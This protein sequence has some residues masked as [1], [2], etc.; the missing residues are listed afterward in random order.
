MLDWEIKDTTERLRQ[1]RCIGQN[2]RRMYTEA[3]PLSDS[4][5]AQYEETMQ[6]IDSR[7]HFDDEIGE[8]VELQLMLEA[9]LTETVSN[10]R[11]LERKLGILMKVPPAQG[12]SELCSNSHNSSNL[13]G[14]PF[15]TQF[16]EETNANMQLASTA[17]TMSPPRLC[18]S[19]DSADDPAS[20]SK[21]YRLPVSEQQQLDQ[22]SKT[23]SATNKRR[24]GESANSFRNGGSRQRKCNSINIHVECDNEWDCAKNH[25]NIAESSDVDERGSYEELTENHTNIESNLDSIYDPVGMAGPLTIRLKHLMREIYD[26]EIEWK[27]PVPRSLAE[28]WNKGDNCLNCFKRRE[29]DW[30]IITEVSFSKHGYKTWYSFISLTFAAAYYGAAVRAMLVKNEKVEH[31]T[32]TFIVTPYHRDSWEAKFGTTD[33][34]YD[35]GTIGPTT[36][37]TEAINRGFDGVVQR[38]AKRKL[39]LFFFSLMPKDIDSAHTRFRE[40][41]N[42][43]SGNVESF[44][45]IDKDTGYL[46]SLKELSTSKQVELFVSLDHSIKRVKDYVREETSVKEVLINHI[47][48]KVLEE[49]TPKKYNAK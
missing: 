32:K 38:P 23:A 44:V 29:M 43:V 18:F 15:A 28:L 6:A 10:Q 5:E 49:P 36:A 8:A 22:G 1:F 3:Q 48:P 13:D 42:E 30:V 20:V 9:R 39:F 33:Q 19:S 41:Q 35:S 34:Y 2:I 24:S 26:A 21:Q 14:T 4:D 37:L 7:T 47:P 27:D 17:R 31:D 25:E 16:D 46:E 12:V 11:R 40:R 45:A